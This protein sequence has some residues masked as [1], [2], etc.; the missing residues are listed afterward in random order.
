[1]SIH[2]PRPQKDVVVV[3]TME[4]VDSALFS[5]PGGAGRGI[6]QEALITQRLIPLGSP[7]SPETA[8]SI[9]GE[10]PEVAG[11][12]EDELY[13]AMD[14]L[15]TGRPRGLL[16]SKST[17]RTARWSSRMY[18]R[19]TIRRIIATWPLWPQPGREEAFPS[20]RL[21]ALVRLGWMLGRK[22][23]R[24]IRTRCSPGIQS[25]GAGPGSSL[26]HRQEKLGGDHAAPGLSRKAVGL[27]APR[28]TWPSREEILRNGAPLPGSGEYPSPSVPLLFGP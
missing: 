23:I 2:V 24:L 21:R 14:A 4:K 6:F 22:G 26:S 13:G 19:S 28:P 16:L 25:L 10:V 20:D 3:G 18:P 12:T 8:T 15:L 1:M 27:P 5:N 17:F 7:L 11:T 9:L